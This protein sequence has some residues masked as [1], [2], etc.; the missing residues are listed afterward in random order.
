MKKPLISDVGVLRIRCER[1]LK[2]NGISY[3]EVSPGLVELTT[4][5][6][7]R[8]LFFFGDK[9]PRSLS[10][11]VFNRSIIEVKSFEEFCKFVL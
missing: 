1:H 5:R 2:E 11:K 8:M 3:A 4:P 6:G 7:Y 9:L 10:P